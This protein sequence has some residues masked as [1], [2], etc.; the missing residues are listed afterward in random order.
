MFLLLLLDSLLLSLFPPCFL[1]SLVFSDPFKYV[2][3]HLVVADVLSC[4]LWWDC[5][6]W[7]CLAWGSPYLVYP[8]RGHPFSSAVPTCGD[9]QP[10]QGLWKWN[11]FKIPH[12]LK[13]YIHLKES[14]EGVVVL[15]C[16]R[17]ACCN[18]T[19]YR[20]EHESLPEKQRKF[21]KQVFSHHI[22]EEYNYDGFSNIWIALVSTC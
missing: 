13:D 14:P 19:S 18:D 11:L 7:L 22:L 21:S 8:H 3:P 6:S 17:W 5:C 15:A 16:V 4:V 10:I 9:L 20:V 12:L 2:F 1:F